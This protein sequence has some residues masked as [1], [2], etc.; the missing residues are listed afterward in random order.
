M[1]SVWDY[2]RPPKL[3]K[4]SKL[5]RVEFAGVTIAKTTGAY[6][7]LETSHPP[8]YYLPKS[9]VE[10]HYLQFEDRTSNCEFKGKANYW[11]IK[12][13]DKISPTAAWSYAEPYEL[14]ASLKE[15]LAF[16]PS[17][18]GSCYV[19]KEQVSAQAGDFYGGWITADIKGPFKGDKGTEGW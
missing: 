12:V 18:V 15:C 7:V 9:D 1:E 3:E 13:G 2:P 4:T 6:R 14:F 19:D 17:R 5:I 11:T 16:Y 10:M 8:T